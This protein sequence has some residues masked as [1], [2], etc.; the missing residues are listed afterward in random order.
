MIR[1]IIRRIL[2]L[3]LPPNAKVQRAEPAVIARE[4]HGLHREQFSP[5]SRRVCE[6]L[7][8]KGYQAY[9]VGGA[10]RDLLNG[11]RPKDFDVATDA[12]PEE[13]RRCLKRS[14]LIGRRFQIVHAYMGQEIVEITTFRGQP[15]GK[16]KTDAHGRVL[17]DNMFGTQAEDAARRDFTVNALY[18]DPASERILDYHHGFSDLRQKTLRVIGDP[19]TRYRED[20][21]RMLR[22]MRLSA[23]LGLSIEPDARRPIREM[24]SLLENVPPARLFDET[25]KILTS[26]YAAHCL[27]ALRSEGLHRGILPLLDLALEDPQ[28]EK[29]IFCALD[30]TDQRARAGKTTSPAFLFAALLWHKTTAIWK[31]KETEGESSFSALHLAMEE[32]LQA[33]GEKLAI[34]RRVAGDIKEIWL[35]Q[36]R[37]TQRSGKRPYALLE[38]PRF[39]AAHDFL[40]LRTEADDA[41]QELF[42]WWETF[43]DADPEERAQ[44]LVKPAEGGAKKRRRRPRKSAESR[45]QN[46]VT[47]L[48]DSRISTPD[49]S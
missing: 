12:T 45:A 2:R 32:V 28:G 4:R 43:R 16:S 37:F 1:R 41:P 48:P 8:Q 38:H 9:I 18:F 23:K 35:L 36:L 22:A 7:Q 20:P 13:V 15:D 6:T 17:R 27:K 33:Q 3:P 44:M 5:G 24:A 40:Y 26:G 49:C 47:L 29:F 34:T 14:R 10:V 25:L 31:K 42:A 46:A 30:S 39:R 21:V 11:L 19:K